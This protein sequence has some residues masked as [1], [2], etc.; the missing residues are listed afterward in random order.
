MLEVT[1]RARIVT[2][3]VAGIAQLEGELPLAARR[4]TEALDHRSGNQ[5][6]LLQPGHVLHQRRHQLEV[7]LQRDG[8]SACRE[9]PRPSLFEQVGRLVGLAE[10]Q[11][12]GD[13][14]GLNREDARKDEGGQQ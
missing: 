1:R 13:L 3:V 8:V 12:H 7:G 10:A 11:H 14:V 4:S 5:L 9:G 6:G 2:E